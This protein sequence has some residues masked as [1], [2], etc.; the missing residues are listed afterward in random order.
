MM[1]A[2]GNIR[3]FRTKSKIEHLRDIYADD[4]TVYLEFDKRNSWRNKENVRRVLEVIEIFYLWSEM[5]IN[6]GKTYVTIFGRELNKPRFV[7]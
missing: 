6:L 1:M 7:E 5:K 4:L 2:K 3:P